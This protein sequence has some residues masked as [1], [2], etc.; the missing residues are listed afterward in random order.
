[1]LDYNTNEVTEGGLYAPDDWIA[2]IDARTD[3]AQRL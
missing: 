1:M 2:G 3:R